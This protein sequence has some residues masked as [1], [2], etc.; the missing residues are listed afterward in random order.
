MSKYCNCC[1]TTIQ[2]IE[3]HYD[4]DGLTKASQSPEE[5]LKM[6]DE[7]FPGEC[8]LTLADVEEYLEIIAA[9]RAS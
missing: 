8:D 1:S 5:T 3:Q 7:C 2:H 4:P 6:F 9:R